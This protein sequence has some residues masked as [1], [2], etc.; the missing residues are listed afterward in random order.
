MMFHNIIES[1]KNSGEQDQQRGKFR[2]RLAFF[3]VP[4]DNALVLSCILFILL[5]VLL[6]PK[7]L[8]RL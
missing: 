1:R 5:F 3:A 8:K 6:C 7:L 4:A 2:E